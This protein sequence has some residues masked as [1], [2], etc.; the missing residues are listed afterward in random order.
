MILLCPDDLAPFTRVNSIGIESFFN[1]EGEYMDYC[2]LRRDVEIAREGDTFSCS[3][4]FPL[5]N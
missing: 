4:T 3:V 5:W 2:V 1:E